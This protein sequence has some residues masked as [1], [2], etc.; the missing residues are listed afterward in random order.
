[1]NLEIIMLSKRSQ[2]EKSTYC[3]IPFRLNSKGHNLLNSDTRQLNVPG[4]GR[5]QDGGLH[6]GVNCEGDKCVHYFECGDGI[7]TY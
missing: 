7:L 4:D 1:M 2:T 5:G 6:S 3:R